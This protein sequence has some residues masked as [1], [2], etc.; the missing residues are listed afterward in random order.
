MC[1]G[2]ITFALN[3]PKQSCKMS[4]HIILAINSCDN[5]QKFTVS[6]VDQIH[7]WNLV[8]ITESD[9]KGIISRNHL[10]IEP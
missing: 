6:R 10:P 4:V 1:C 9:C 7:R 2:S 3:F 8:I 5:A